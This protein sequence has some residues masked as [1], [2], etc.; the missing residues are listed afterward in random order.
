MN[1]THNPTSQTL[2][3]A[4]VLASLAGGILLTSAQLARGSDDQPTAAPQA[5]PTETHGASPAD[6][7][8]AAR[9][10]FAE[11]DLVGGGEQLTRLLDIHREAAS[12]DRSLNGRYL[13][14]RRLAEV[15]HEYLR[16][17]QLADAMNVM[18]EAAD[19]SLPPQEGI[20]DGLASAAG[21]LYRQL[22]VL[23]AEERFELLHDWSMP[24]DDRRTVRV[25]TSITPTNAPPS[26]FAR[27]LGE[28]SRRGSFAVAEIGEVRGLFCSAWELVKA[29]DEAGALRRLTAELAGLVDDDTPNARFALT[30]A[31]IAG[32]RRADEQLVNELDAY[33]LR[34]GDRSVIKSDDEDEQA[35][36]PVTEFHGPVQSNSDV[37][38]AAA[39]LTQASLRPIGER[40][41]RTKLEQTYGSES[42]FMQ[43]FLRTAHATALRTRYDDASPDVA[44]RSGLE[45]WVEGQTNIAWRNIQGAVPAVWLSH[46]DHVMHLAGPRNEYLFLKYPLLG[47]FKFSCDAQLGGP[48]GTDGCLTYGGLGYE[49][50]GARQL[51]KVWDANFNK[52][53]EQSC[54]FAP[55]D[56]VPTFHRFALTSKPDGVSFSVNQHPLWTDDSK[57]QTT[58]WIGLRSFGDR[59]PIFRN[60]K[61]TGDPI[62]PREVKMSDGNSL[63]GWVA[64]YYGERTPPPAPTE[65]GLDSFLTRL[66]TRYDWSANGGVIRGARQVTLDD[67]VVQSRLYYFRPL[68]NDESVSYEFQYEPGQLEVHPTLG[69]VA[70]LIEPAGVRLHWMTDG[71]REWTG[72]AE[73]NSVVEPLN[74]RGPKPLPL[75]SG[76]WNRVTLAM[77]RETLTLSL[78]DT[79]IYTRKMERDSD[80][81]F[82][83]YHDKSRS[84]ARV[85]S[86]VMRGDWPEQL[87]DEQLN[88]L[89]ALSSPD[90]STDD[91]RVLGAV[92]DDQHVYGSVLALHRRAATLPPKERYDLLS[93][94][95]LPGPDH[96]T[97]R[98]AADFTPTN[99]APPVSDT[100]VEAFRGQSRVTTGGDLVSPAL[101]LVATAKELDQLNE[102][103]ERVATITPA[104]EQQRR[105]QLGMMAVI[106]IARDDFAKAKVAIDEL[107]SI[108]RSSAA[109]SFSERWPETLTIWSAT[110][111]TETRDA[112]RDM[113]YQILVR[114]VRKKFPSGN[115]AWDY[116]V[117]ALASRVR[118]LDLLEADPELERSPE[119][120][121][122]GQSPLSNWV[123]ASRETTRTRGKGFPRSYWARTAPTAVEN[124]ASHDADYLFY[125]LP[126]RG[127]FEVECDVTGFGYREANMWVAGRW[128]GPV[129][130]L[131]HVDVSDF[132][133]RQRLPLD[134]PI[135]KPNAWIHYRTV[136]RDGVCTVY[137]NGR[138]IHQRPLET[139]H[140][141][142]VAVHSYHTTD[143]GVRNLRITG[144]PKIP[145]EVRL[146]ANADLPGWLPINIGH[147]VSP[148]LKWQQLGDLE[149]GGGI[150]GKRWPSLPGSH[151]ETLLR[152]HRPM[153]EDGT[154]EYEFYYQPGEVLVHPTLDR[155]AFMLH[156]EGIR[157]HWVTDGQFDRTGLAPDNLFDEPDNR[158]G[159]QPLPLKQN[160]WNRLQLSLV[161][162]TVD[163]TL[164][165][166]LVFERELEP[167][168]QRTFG[169]FH[170]ADR[171]EAL[172]RNVVWRGDW[173]RELPAITEQ[174]L[175]G[176]GS[177]FLDNSRE[178]LTSV[179]HH[180]FAKDG[181]STDGFGIVVGQVETFDPQPQ[182]LLVT[183]PGGEG[184][185]DS[186]IAPHLTIQG[187]FD[188]VA[189][190]DG[191]VPEPQE[192]GSSAVFLQAIFDNAKSNECLV[193]R[194]RYWRR[195]EPQP[196]IQAY[197]VTREIGGARRHQFP[198]RVAEAPGGRL[199]LARR[200]DTVYYLFAEN[201][202]PHFRLLATQA[203][204]VGDIR[205]LRLLTQV[206][207]EG[208]TRV[209]WKSL[210][211][212]ADKLE[213][214]ALAGQD[215]SLLELNRQ[216]DELSDRFVQDFAKDPFTEDRFHRWGRPAR[217]S[218]NG[219]H[220]TARGTD[221]WTSTGLAP[222]LGVQGDF[223]VS[224]TF[225]ELRLAKPKDK[226]NSAF[227]L[228]VE[229]PDE[230]RT[231]ANV[232]FVEHIVG[233]PQVYAQIRIVDEGGNN[234]Y[235][236]VRTDTAEAL[237][238]MRLA[239]RGEDIFFVYRKRGS[240][241]DHIFAQAN[242]GTLPVPET[243]IRLM[244]H[245]GGAGRN[246]TVLLKELRV[247]AEEIDPIPPDASPVLEALKKQLT[248]EVP[249]HALEFDGRTQYVTIPSIRYDGSHPITLEAFVT[250][251][252]VRGVVVGD[253]QQSG[254]ALGILNQKFNIHAWNGTGY[255]GAVPS[256]GVSR[257]LRVHLAGTFDG[258]TLSLFINGKLAKRRQL[259]GPF[260]GSGL[261]MTIG[262]SPSPNERGIDVAFDGLIDQ[263]RISKA[264]RYE[265]DFEVPRKFESNEATLALF[266]FDE[267][268]GQRLVDAS[269]NNHHGEVR[270]AQWVDSIATRRRAAMGL[271]DFRRY[272]V[273]LLTEALGHENPDV[274]L[275]ATSAL[276]VIGPDAQAA[277]PALRALAD[278]DDERVRAGAA[279]ALKLIEARGVLNSIFNL[280]N[281]SR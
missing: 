182:G 216:R 173:P 215:K 154:I 27:A 200:G 146:T 261:P 115:V 52:L 253:T 2:S 161:G 145:A 6:L 84:E 69:Q 19:L 168:N 258:E 204:V 135:H 229:F 132:R 73:N 248:G 87:T 61:I 237:E 124:F 110:P 159:Q 239:R 106:D 92:F 148:G 127:N 54:P 85:R 278:H 167:T 78:N 112:V 153:A 50:W 23:D 40:I 113:A 71:D 33:A 208:M 249:G 8:T 191:F 70:F 243:A 43:P 116:H 80:R 24:T 257:F 259:T 264:I 62:I 140:D 3:R 250:P 218:G 17:G 275:E 166:E 83:F 134:P 64:S 267:A 58:P 97:L 155:M 118:Y 265:D 143:G 270:G 209:V 212:R 39:C 210:T 228:Q 211:I 130:T 273:P 241:H 221:N 274:Q 29:A 30:L 220:V 107:A 12:K 65:F 194:R 20:D 56:K 129:Y 223:D 139:E 67:A 88:N 25:L 189:A 89:T 34:L 18:G 260:N 158:R 22:A 5:V 9:Q 152:Y 227:Y 126:L 26:V 242:V 98:L 240:K 38:L 138:K 82:G 192:G 238:G 178:E 147:R 76:E 53:V 49:V 263:V 254:I 234:I 246:S 31:K 4:I 121:S 180:D 128:V 214:L 74:R 235:R 175:A 172:V 262:A 32:S 156:P 203:E 201:D 230:K 111:F 136:V 47:D 108:A 256:A 277:I 103:R 213:G 169:L 10:R 179:F 101:D 251:D 90:R 122:N 46:Q 171:T 183:R 104:N 149:N 109:V 164:N 21:G 202:S 105:C 193:A 185:N 160:D 60:I 117:E 48:G 244:L 55:K 232:I 188:I 199:R 271:A 133:G 1:R 245:T 114:Q 205:S 72:L 125:R 266:R 63:R 131:R 252:D 176:E 165:D 100:D 181:L 187:D 268:G 102:L 13:W 42:L 44:S 57:D 272:A 119:E 123:P 222:H 226:L 7:K 144:E 196:L 94:W 137:S 174:E 255:D 14:S 269:G 190:F 45:L 28:R 141:P 157:V 177:E 93:E 86:V 142:W 35:S 281:S 96:E 163:L 151:W 206:H 150:R 186:T 170:Y 219:L 37:A 59:T 91:R 120:Q 66:T 16:A 276:A 280:F 231:Q 41:L 197:Y 224:V 195:A 36:D 75:K 77:K 217:L 198:H 207:L 81:T 11:A 51:L 95:V 233:D 162:D 279:R 68:L 15:A 184:Y 225:D 79:A 236:R 247:R 99:P